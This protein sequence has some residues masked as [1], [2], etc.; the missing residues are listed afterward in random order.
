M[1]ALAPVRSDT[2]PENFTYRDDGCDISPSCLNCPLPV[3][4]YDD[5]DYLRRTVRGAR[6]QAIVEA[7]ERDRLPVPALASRFGVSTRTVH[8]VLQSQRLGSRRAPEGTPSLRLVVSP[9]RSFR[10]PDP[11]PEIWP[12]ASAGRFGAALPGR[13]GGPR[14]LV[15][16]TAE[17][18][19][20]GAA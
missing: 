3:C 13:A 6:D 8:R 11:L 9:A 7:R 20:A 5:P 1:M 19:L 18:A 2:L 10:A 15:R 14:E 17:P 12:A 16:Q 4:K